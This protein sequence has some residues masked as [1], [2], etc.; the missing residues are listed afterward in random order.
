MNKTNRKEKKA[1][2]EILKKMRAGEIKTDNNYRIFEIDGIYMAARGD[3]I[4]FVLDSQMAAW[5]ED[6]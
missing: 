3:L 4:P 1:K 5:L 6:V 2:D